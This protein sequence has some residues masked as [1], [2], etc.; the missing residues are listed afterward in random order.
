MNILNFCSTIC[1]MSY[2]NNHNNMRYI[3]FKQYHGFNFLFKVNKIIWVTIKH[4]DYI[5]YQAN[6]AD[7]V[8]VALIIKDFMLH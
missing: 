2:R 8:N 5:E 4:L 3:P 1:I 7:G 6:M